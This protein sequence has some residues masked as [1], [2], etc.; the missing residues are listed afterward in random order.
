[1]IFSWANWD[2]ME[3]KYHCIQIVNTHKLFH[4]HRNKSINCFM[5]ESF[6]VITLK[7]V[8]NDGNIE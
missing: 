7:L 4:S 2:K 5:D 1:M 6:S 3:D 8:L